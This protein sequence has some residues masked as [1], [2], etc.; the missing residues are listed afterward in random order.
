MKTLDEHNKEHYYSSDFSIAD[1]RLEEK[2]AGI[3][4]DACKMEMISINPGQILCSYPPMKEVKCSSCH[5][6]G[7]MII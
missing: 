6:I 5:K 4:C 2:R 3:L 7:Y 1:I